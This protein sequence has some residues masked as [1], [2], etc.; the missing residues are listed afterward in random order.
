L[1]VSVPTLSWNGGC[2]LIDERKLRPQ[3]QQMKICRN[4]YLFEV[5]EAGLRNF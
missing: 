3:K 1:A 2:F 5:S 4:Q